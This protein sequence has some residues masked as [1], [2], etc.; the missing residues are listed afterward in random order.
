VTPAV[1]AEVEALA[2]FNLRIHDCPE[3]DPAPGGDTCE[4]VLGRK[5]P[6][7]AFDARCIADATTVAAIRAC[8][9]V[10]CAAR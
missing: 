7:L 2:C 9:N 1:D 6:R 5:D 10:R 8:P 4:A 3:G